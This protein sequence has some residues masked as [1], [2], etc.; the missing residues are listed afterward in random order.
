[1]HPS[2]SGDLVAVDPKRTVFALIDYQND[3]TSDGGALH[4]AVKASWRRRTCSRTR[5]SSSRRRERPARRRVHDAHRLREGLRG[6]H[7]LAGELQGAPV[8]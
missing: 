6:D 4:D 3:F 5:A 1:M 2:A 7:A 8:A